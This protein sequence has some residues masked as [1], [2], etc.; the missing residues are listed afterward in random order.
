MKKLAIITTH[1]IQYNAP[2]FALLSKRGVVEP[3]VFYTWGKSVLNDKF[4]PGFGK[5]I[6]WDIPLLTGYE[7]TFVNNLASKPGSH[8]FLGIDNPTLVKEITEWGADAILVFGWAFKSHL[9]AMRYFKGKIPVLFRGDSTILD[10]YGI[11][12]HFARSMLLRWVYR[13]IDIALYVGKA[14]KQYFLVNKVSL[15][16]LVHA[17]HSIDNERFHLKPEYFEKAQELKKELNLPNEAVVFL[18]AAKFEEKKDPIQLIRAFKLVKHPN[19][20]LVMIGN[21]PLEDLVYGEAKGDSRI[22]FLPFQNQSMMPVIYHLGDIYVLPS[23]GP[24]TWGLAVNEAMAAGKAVLVSN[25]CGCA[26][27]LVREGEN[28]YIFQSG[29]FED[30]RKHLQIVADNHT[31]LAEMGKRS[32]EIIKDFNFEKI[33]EVIE[34]VTNAS[35]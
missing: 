15:N 13:Y 28:G 29:N 25:T 8:H 17:P 4:D 10:P 30:L 1:P 5:T 34:N 18:F 23:L 16:K 14:N 32:L 3:K 22:H 27:D 12:K 26:E 33:C 21:G 2:L 31:R 11:V 9:R 24:E 20:H 7:Y 19:C 6:K 35:K